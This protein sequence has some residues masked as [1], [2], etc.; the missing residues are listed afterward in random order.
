M[1]KKSLLLMF[2]CYLIWG[3]QPLYWSLM[4]HMDPY[5]LMAV[6]TLTS[7]GFSIAVLAAQ[8]RLPELTSLLKDKKRMK[9]LAPATFLLFIDWVVYLVA[10]QNG[11][12]LDTSLGY[13][14]GPIVVFSLSMLLFKE[15]CT[16]LKGVAMGL[17]IA[18]ITVTL[19]AFGRFPLVSAVLAV[20]FSVY[21]ALKKCIKV[22][23]VLS[24]AAETLLL[25]PFALLFL[26]FFRMG[27]NGL[28]SMTITDAL[29]FLGAGVITAAP[30]MLYSQG[31]NN[32][33]F[34]MIGFFQYMSPTLSMISGFILGETMAPDRLTSF[35][36]IWA[37]LIV[38]SISIVREE[39]ARK[40]L[41][42]VE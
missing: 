14:L 30:M 17:T 32:L 20:A 42:I 1:N 31:V 33:S 11:Q 29:L 38:F 3:F 13:L 5:Y 12:V 2:I 28:A 25:S 19:I 22:E 8:K 7:A 35:V 10:V 6:R 16:P 36:F 24:I 9:F 26:L 40:K 4:G 37:A 23:S 15:K 34:M 27:E 21:G 41:Q 39:R 18:G